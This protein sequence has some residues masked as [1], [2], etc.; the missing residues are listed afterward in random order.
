MIWKK[1]VHF[2]DLKLLSVSGVNKMSFTKVDGTITLVPSEQR[3]FTDMP[4][5][6]KKWQRKQCFYVKRY[7]QFNSYWYK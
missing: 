3:Q 2:K 7:M 5:Q 1:V 6:I 4:I